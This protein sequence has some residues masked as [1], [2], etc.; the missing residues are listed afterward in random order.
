MQQP[1]LSMTETD[2]VLPDGAFA[3]SAAQRGIWFAQ[4]IAGDTPISIA[5]YVELTG[6]IDLDL[7]ARSARRAG[8]EFGTGYLRLIEVDGHPFQF[9]DTTLDD[10]LDIIDFRAE[11]DPEAAAQAWMRTDYAA[12]LD[13]TS[14]R[15]L[16]VAML[17]IG[18]DRWFWYSRIHHIVLD[19][20]GA[21]TV[22]QRTGEL[23]N[24]A[25]EGRQPPQAKAE[26]LREIVDADLAYRSS[27]R[28][29]A[30]R[31][32]WLE[33][34]DGMAD[35]VSLAGRTAA[36]D[37]HPSRVAGALP[38]DTA[39]LLD[40]VA[41]EV[42][43]GVAP[44]VVAAF[45]AYLSS[46]TGAP[47]VVLSL[48]VSARTT[49]TLRR[50]G[51]M[52]ANVV[53][54][55]LRLA[56]T[57]T[58][59]DVIKAAQ[60]ELTGALRRQRYRQEDIVR[61]L[62]WP[63]DES[64]S[65]GPSVNLMMVDTRIQLGT[66]TGRLHVLTSGLIE[67]LFVNL[68]PG[69]GGESTHIDLQA[70]GNLYTDAELA[71]QH[72]R[73]LSF[74]HRFLS[75]GPDA[76]V[77]TVPV[78]SDGERAD[79]A[80]ARGPEGVAPRTLPAI[81]AD[82]AALDPQA[83]ALVDGTTALTYREVDDYTNRL[84]RVLIAAGAGPERT[85]AISIPRSVRS[86][87]ATLAVAKT[88]AAFVPI[89]PTYPADRIEHMVGD[90]GVVAGVT[91]ATARKSL[92]DRVNWLIVDDESTEHAVAEQ[93]AAAITDAD[94]WTA[95]HPDQVAYII[96]TSGSTG[97]PK[98]VLVAHRGLADLVASSGAGFG[99]DADSIVAHAVSPS[100]DI[101]V[102]EILVT[103][104][105]GATLAV[106]PPSAYAGEEMAQVLRANGV[107]HLNVTPTVV[108]SLEPATLP[109]CAP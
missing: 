66:V 80:P 25:V 10:S 22:V 75:A 57:T 48:P 102:E 109:V 54:L 97:L 85:V 11:P 38:A 98:G 86:V 52:I 96:Y 94:R 16:R 59:G 44:T 23:Y 9:V 55:R 82:G 12:P 20:M 62:G 33:H 61:D 49:A 95:V 8:R 21:L 35:P 77:A 79:Y 81:L 88:G 76:P 36:V 78:L 5:Q 7:L 2:T 70:N 40:S 24:A 6:P 53:P 19:G 89:D 60:G 90:S 15:L 83:T 46:M 64:A 99:V 51:G 32:Y 108:G 84:A 31:E 4:H 17:R 45:G 65:F 29:T 30:D 28:F 56:P 100:F 93:D 74:L 47:E 42:S 58:V 103:L 92:P 18:S 104:A 14:D 71:A 34:L 26:D 105:A 27:N 43:S 73:F 72:R 50:S 1:S 39:E 101:S 106:V 13:L 91:I 87:L 37:A 3:L 41:K 107:T 63:M 67:D 69:V 68:Y